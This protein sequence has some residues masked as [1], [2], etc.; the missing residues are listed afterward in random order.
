MYFWH[1]AAVTVFQN[2]WM[3]LTSSSFV[4]GFT[5]RRR[6]S[7]SSCHMF[8]IGLKSGDSGG[9]GHHRTSFSSKNVCASRD[10]CLGSL[11][12]MNLCPFIYERQESSF[13]DICVQDGIHFSLEDADACSTT[14]A[15]PRPNVDLCRVLCPARVHVY[16]KH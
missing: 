9:V 11:S 7:L 6:Y 4:R 10:V 3:P 1:F 8:S 13:E 5:S 15:D 16:K 14:K 12:C 2:S